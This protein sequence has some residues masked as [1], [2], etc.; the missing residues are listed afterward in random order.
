MHENESEKESEN[1]L[2]FRIIIRE[3]VVFDG[4]GQKDSPYSIKNNL[5]RVWSRQAPPNLSS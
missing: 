2:A 5:G 1:E 4:D 3:F